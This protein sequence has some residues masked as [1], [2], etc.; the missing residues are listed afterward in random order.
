MKFIGPF[1][2]NNQT[3]EMILRAEQSWENYGFGKFAVELVGTGE[4]IGFIGLT[5]CKFESHFTP[6][7]EIGWRLSSKFW[8]K[9]Y[10]TEGALAVLGWATDT[11][12]L[13]EVVSFTSQSNYS[14]RRVMEKI[15]MHHD[16]A[17]D[18]QHPNLK[19]GNPLRPHVLYRKR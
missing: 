15:G 17:D 6:A 12:L 11:L 10:A 4:L 3:Q 5:Q 16:P 2:T 18:F 8:N 14:S 19:P 7:V 9:G 13:T 1:L